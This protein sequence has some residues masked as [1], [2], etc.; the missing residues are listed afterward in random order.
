MSQKQ[1]HPKP[2]TNKYNGDSVDM[3]HLLIGLSYTRKDS[4]PQQPNHENS[5]IKELPNLE[6]GTEHHFTETKEL[7]SDFQLEL[8]A[9]Y[10]CPTASYDAKRCPPDLIQA[11]RHRLAHSVMKF[12]PLNIPD[13]TCESTGVPINRKKLKLFCSMEKLFHLGPVIPMYF[14]YLK[15][16]AIFTFLLSG[17]GIFALFFRREHSDTTYHD[18]LKEFRI[19]EKKS[20]MLTVGLFAFMVVSFFLLYFFRRSQ[21]IA[22]AACKKTMVTPS[23]YSIMAYNMGRVHT[24]EEAKHFFAT[25]MVH[26]FSLDVQKVIITHNIEKYAKKVRQLKR[27]LIQKAQA[28]KNA[29]YLASGVLEDIH[30]KIE[31]INQFFTQNK[32]LLTGFRGFKRNGLC[33]VTF[34]NKQ[35]AKSVRRKFEFSVLERALIWVLE[36]CTDEFPEYFFRDHYI[37]VEKAPEMN[38]ILWENLNSNRTKFGL[39]FLNRLLCLAFVAITSVSLIFLKENLFQTSPY[40]IHLRCFFIAIS[41]E[42][43]S[44]MIYFTAKYEPFKTITAMSTIIERRIAIFQFLN[45]VLPLLLIDKYLLSQ[46]LWSFPYHILVLIS[47]TSFFPIVLRAINLP[48]HQKQAQ[49]RRVIRKVKSNSNSSGITQEEA[50]S[51]FE[52]PEFDVLRIYADAN[53]TLLICCLFFAVSPAV[54]PI[55]LLSF[56]AGHFVDKYNLLRRSLLPGSIRSEI[57]EEMFEFLDVGLFFVIIGVNFFLDFLEEN[58]S[59]QTLCNTINIFATVLAVIYIA[60]PNKRFARSCFAKK[61]KLVWSDVL[62]FS[63]AFEY[64]GKDYQN[65]NV[66]SR[67]S[68]KDNS[69]KLKDLYKNTLEHFKTIDILQELPELLPL[70]EYAHKKPSLSELSKREFTGIRNPFYTFPYNYG[71]ADDPNYTPQSDISSNPKTPLMQDQDLEEGQSPTNTKNKKKV[72]LNEMV[73]PSFASLSMSFDNRSRFSESQSGKGNNNSLMKDIMMIPSFYG[74]GEPDFQLHVSSL[75]SP[76]FGPMKNQHQHQQQQQETPASQQQEFHLETPVASMPLSETPVLEGL[77]PISG[78]LG[79]KSDLRG[80]TCL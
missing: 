47:V 2:T 59:S 42:I 57:A 39:T 65:A 72:K 23:D 22:K 11:E 40:E 76:A 32:K 31:Q 71:Y 15:Q 38:E 61:K 30:I 79:P 51:S 69:Q 58:S 70:F 77:S 10:P 48:Y 44:S 25:S 35:E 50:N 19:D 3:D 9:V 53:R 41:N 37:K 78:T 73:P 33:F 6:S 74:K 29:N 64:F 4:D 45:S 7:A 20:L 24:E 52:L 14:L 43:L 34:S 5:I 56:I 27:L 67:D 21:K 26:G 68:F 36:K 75:T 49:R 54:A 80:S 46:Q 63:Q 13:D 62:L 60:M 1:Q 16:L 12:N 55:A 66:V 8:P 17:L 18:I 28:E